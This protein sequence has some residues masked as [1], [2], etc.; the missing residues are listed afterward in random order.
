MIKDLPNGYIKKQFPY[1]VTLEHAYEHLDRIDNWCWQEF[2]PRQGECYYRKCEWDYDTW[3]TESGYEKELD[4]LLDEVCHIKMKYDQLSWEERE[5]CPEYQ[6][7]SEYTSMVINEHFNMLKE[8]PLENGQPFEHSHFG[9]W[10]TIN[11][12]KTGY[13]FGFQ[14]YIFR[15]HEDSTL[16]AL[17]WKG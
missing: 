12:K 4:T 8:A 5:K 13:D 7:W 11:G 14:D 3:H 1:S 9:K 16:F 2:G 10:S 17:I 15:N 6:L